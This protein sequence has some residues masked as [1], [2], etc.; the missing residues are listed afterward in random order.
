LR[1]HKAAVYN[2][3]TSTLD[4]CGVSYRPLKDALNITSDT[5]V[6]SNNSISALEGIPSKHRVVWGHLDLRLARLRKHRDLRAALG[7]R[8]HL[9]VPSKYSARRTHLIIPFRSRRVIEHGVDDVFL[10]FEARN[11]PPPP[12]VIFASQPRR[13]LHLVLRVWQGVIHPRQPAAR[14]HLYCSHQDAAGFGITEWEREGIVFKGHVSHKLLSQ[15]FRE[16]RLMLYPGHKEETYCNTAAEAVASGL[17][18]VTMG[19]GA[20]AERV[21]HRVDGLLASSAGEM[22]HYAL[23]V[24]SDDCLWHRLHVGGIEGSKSRSWDMRAKEWELAAKAW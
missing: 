12:I 3:R 14:L 1:G 19:I 8:P 5:I 20:L 17:P 13:N 24:L 16:G 22:G 4:V 6:V 23:D 21:R 9:V 11:Q 15:G 18:V 7:I 2:H 10:Q